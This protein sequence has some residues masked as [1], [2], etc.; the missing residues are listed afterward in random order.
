MGGDCVRFVQR[1]LHLAVIA[2]RKQLLGFVLRGCRSG[3]VGAVRVEGAQ[4]GAVG[5]VDGGAD[6]HLNVCF[7]GKEKGGLVFT[8]RCGGKSSVLYGYS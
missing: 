3:Y 4:A 2:F 1:V 7:L 5:G 6:G 8:G